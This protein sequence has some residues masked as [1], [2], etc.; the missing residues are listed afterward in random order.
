M[1]TVYSLIANG[2]GRSVALLIDPD[3]Y[4]EADCKR[5]LALAKDSPVSMVLVGGSLVC[6]SMPDFIDMVKRYTSLPVLLFPGSSYQFAPNADAMLYLSLISGRNPEF[7]IGNHVQVSFRVKQSGLEVIPTGYILV[8]GG[9]VTSVQY[10]SNTMAIP[11]GKPELVA[12]TALAGEQ[13]GMRLI[14]LEAGSGADKPVST[15]IIERVKHEVTIPIIVGGGIRT[16]KQLVNAFEAG[17]NIVVL[18]NSVE[19]N[20][21]LLITLL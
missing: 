5:V 11:S 12:A 21:E 7:L 17:A 2:P 20:P 16:R 14:Y 13:L 19:E 1:Q 15:E 6:A 18:G 3:S 9:T 8:D 4:T 10:M